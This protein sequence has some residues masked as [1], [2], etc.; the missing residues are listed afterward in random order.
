MTPI[1]ENMAEMF[2]YKDDGHIELVLKLFARLCDGQN[3]GI[4]VFF[5]FI[6]RFYKPKYL[7][8]FFAV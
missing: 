3:T 2:Q 7:A 1:I 5:S 6:T 4:Q 8:S